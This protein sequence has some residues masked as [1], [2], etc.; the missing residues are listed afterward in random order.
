MEGS[1]EA[2]A[3]ASLRSGRGERFQIIISKFDKKYRENNKKY[4]C[5]TVQGARGP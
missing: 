4:E 1:K 3:W 2:S 5:A